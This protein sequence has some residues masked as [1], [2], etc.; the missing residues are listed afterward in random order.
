MNK[1]KLISFFDFNLN[2][3]DWF[4]RDFQS[5]FDILHAQMR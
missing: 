4:A 5:K 3:V 2:T 1:I